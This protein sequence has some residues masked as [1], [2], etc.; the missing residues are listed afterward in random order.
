MEKLIKLH[1]EV[2]WI[3]HRGLASKILEN[4]SESFL[5]AA[6]LPF[7]GIETDIHLTLD[8]VVIVHHDDSTKRLSSYDYIINKTPHHILETVKLKLK[9]QIPLFSEYLNICKLYNKYAIIELKAP[10]DFEQIKHILNQVN[11]INH[12]DQT[13]IISFIPNNLITVR[14][15]Y[16]NLKLQLLSDKLNQEVINLAVSYRFDLSLHHSIVSPSIVKQIHNL[17]LEIGVWTVN[18][19]AR[20]V[21]LINMGIDYITT[22]GID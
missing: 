20:A 8:Q 6:K 14:T 9:Y 21:E 10:F 11:V 22:D 7:F 3:A 2:K 4:T 5:A 15:L 19:Q 1:P 17:N 18:S 16:P 12:I 13:I